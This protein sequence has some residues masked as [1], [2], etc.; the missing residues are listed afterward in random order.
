MTGRELREALTAGRRVYGTV[1]ISTST[2]WPQTVSPIGMDFVFMDTEHIT[3][4]RAPLSW[5]CQ[6]YDALGIAPVVRIHS[7]DPYAAC[8]VLDGGAK[9]LIAPYIEKPEQV[10]PLVGAVKLRPLKGDRLNAALEVEG[11]ERSAV[12]GEKLGDYLENANADRSL[13]V[14]IESL[15][16]VEALEE[17]CSVEGLDAILI[18]PHDLSCSM[19][20][21]EEYE[22]PVF[23]DM[24]TRIIETARSVGVGAGIHYTFTKNGTAQEIE[25]IRRG[26]NLIIHG[27]DVISFVDHMGAELAELRK[28]FGD[29]KDAGTESDGSVTV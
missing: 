13:I 8:K 4:D 5:M 7:P 23:V 28:A 26:A 18:G 3:M 15:P 17:I 16:A 29:V 21:P 2:R 9:G 27:A 1:I 10:V 20:I 24:V 12:L 6:C 11:E 19:G 22:N 25:W 14:N